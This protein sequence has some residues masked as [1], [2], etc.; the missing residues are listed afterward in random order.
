MNMTEMQSWHRAVSTLSE[1]PLTQLCKNCLC[2]SLIRKQRDAIP[3]MTAVKSDVKLDHLS[4]CLC[5]S[6]AEEQC[7][8]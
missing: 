6:P 5:I 4:R 1:V 3:F 8:N 7:L 2:Q